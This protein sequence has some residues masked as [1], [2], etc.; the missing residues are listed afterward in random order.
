MKLA[1]CMT[2]ADFL[3]HLWHQ[4]VTGRLYKNLRASYVHWYVARPLARV[5]EWFGA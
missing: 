1:A 2:V 4:V 5:A 3:D